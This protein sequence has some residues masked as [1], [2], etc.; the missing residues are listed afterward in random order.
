MAEDLQLNLQRGRSCKRLRKN[1]RLNGSAISRAVDVDRDCI[2]ERKT[3]GVFRQEAL[4]RTWDNVAK[5]ELRLLDKAR[6]NS[7]ETPLAERIVA[8][9]RGCNLTAPLP[10]GQR[11]LRPG[12]ALEM[13]IR[14][15]S[16]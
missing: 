4:K 5:L 1:L 16:E 14:V 15:T 13:V 10:R 8:W 2:D 11:R 3:L 7:Y 12:M 6:A 9:K